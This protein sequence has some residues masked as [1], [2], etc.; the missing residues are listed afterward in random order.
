LKQNCFPESFVK[1]K[2]KT[3]AS[4]VKKLRFDLKDKQSGVEFWS[5]AK[6]FGLYKKTKTNNATW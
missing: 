6:N 4:Q 3:E 1:A 2:Q 5:R